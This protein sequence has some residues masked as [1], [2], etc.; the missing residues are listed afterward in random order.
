MV[1]HNTLLSYYYFNEWFDI[2]TVASNY[3]LGVEIIQ[4]IKPIYFY[5][6]KITVPQTQYTVTEKYLL[7]I[8]DTHL[9][10]AERFY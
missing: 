2:H 6:Q 1:T 8:V 10:N 9:R 7:S 4:V 3:Q 5:R